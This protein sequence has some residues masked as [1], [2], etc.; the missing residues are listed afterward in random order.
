MSSK[1]LR[2]A[3]YN[4]HRCVGTDGRLDMNRI[5][6]VL[7]EIDAD[8]I[9]IQE[10]DSHSIYEEGHQLN[11][12]A[13]LTQY[14]VVAGPTLLRS[15]REYGNALLTRFP[16]KVLRRLDLTMGLSEPRAAMDVDLDIH[17]IHFRLITTHL[18][19]GYRER[20]YQLAK[21]FKGVV[22]NNPLIILGDM[23]EWIPFLGAT[24]IFRKN[25]GYAKRIFTYPSFLPILGLDQIYVSPGVLLVGAEVHKTP[26]A[27]VASDHLPVKATIRV[28]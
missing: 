26:L 8:V 25:F 5:V 13:R 15:D 18:G 10:I 23:N 11:Y 28:A 22:F 1:E 3:T 21:L 20:R 7:K 19:L 6:R 4:I 17:G 2:V 14:H 27:K 16:I 9:G 24:R 12:I